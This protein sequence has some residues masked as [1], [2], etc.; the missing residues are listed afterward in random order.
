MKTRQFVPT[1][2]KKKRIVIITLIILILG[3]FLIR[4]VREFI[5]ATAHNLGLGVENAGYVSMQAGEAVS[6]LAKSKKTL[7]FENEFL[8]NKINELEGKLAN[9]SALLAENK[10]L[11]YALGRENSIKFVLAT[12]ISKPP[13]SLYDTLLVDGGAL[14]GLTEGKIVFSGGE[15]PIGVVEKVY[16]RSALVRI[17]SSSGQETEVRL[18]AISEEGKAV[19]ID[20]KLVGRGGGNFE[21]SIPRDFSIGVNLVARTK[22]INPKVIAK[23]ER[24]ISDPRDPFVKVLLSSPVNINELSFVEVEQ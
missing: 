20:A 23:F 19:H 13:V 22:T 18:D 9:Y 2:N 16:D 5:T 24:I 17:F 7:I 12:V 15:T 21:I 14:S 8:N 1:H 10:E 3:L 4:N 11:K 6:N